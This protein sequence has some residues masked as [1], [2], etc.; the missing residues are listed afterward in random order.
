[1][2]HTCTTQDCLLLAGFRYGWM[3]QSGKGRVEK[4]GENEGGGGVEGMG[5]R[6]G[7]R[8]RKKGG[9]RG[10]G[11]GG[12]KEGKKGRKGGRKEKGREKGGREGEERRDR[13]GGSL[14]LKYVHTSSTSCF[15]KPMD[16]RLHNNANGYTTLTQCPD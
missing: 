3:G 14:E 16:T 13:K 7:R 8:K 12:K 9:E 4:N 11:G 2:V 10:K 1:M 15:R 6:N 5:G